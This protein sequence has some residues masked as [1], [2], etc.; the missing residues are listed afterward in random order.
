MRVLV[1]RVASAR[2]RVEDETIGEINRGLL[3]FVGVGP[4]DTDRD[5]DWMASKLMKLRLF[6][7][8][9]GK[10][11]RTMTDAK[12]EILSVSQFTLYADVYSGNRPGFSGAASPE[13]AKMLWSRLNKALTALGAVVK[14]GRFGAHMEVELVNDGPVTFWIDSAGN[15]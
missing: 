9:G 14:T 6:A 7:D 3:L 13:T 5:V 12:G 11:N 8:D 2:V 4:A 10:M 1:Q 15:V